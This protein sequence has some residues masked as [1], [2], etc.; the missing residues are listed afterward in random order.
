MTMMATSPQRVR[1]A[2]SGFGELAQQVHAR[3]LSRLPNVEI[4][5]IADPNA[6]RCV[7]AQKVFRD[8]PVYG[9]QDEMLRVA[10]CDAV[11]IAASPSD[12]AGLALAALQHRKHVYLEKPMATSL[13]DAIRLVEAW[14]ASRLVGMIGFN[15]RFTPAV[16]SLR[17]RLRAGQLGEIRAIRTV[18]SIFPRNMPAW[19]TTRRTCGGALLDL[20]P[21]HV[22]LIRYLAQAEVEKADARIW[23]EKTED[24]CAALQMTLTN[25]I[26]VESFFSLCRAEQDVIEIDGDVGTALVDRYGSGRV[27]FISAKHNKARLSRLTDSLARF[28]PTPEMW[29]KLQAPW[30]E[31]SYEAALRTFVAAVRGEESVDYPNFEDGWRC[32]AVI[33]AAEESA[34]TDQ[35]LARTVTPVV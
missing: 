22:D 2:L 6:E 16:Q 9:S 15:Y 19:K 28:L 11:L 3:I 31:P 23:S 1:I 4:A 14:R 24:D 7:A 27:R 18:F 13:P 33:A 20:A 17:A 5:G 34:P 30:H 26:N 25:G 10:K 21:H 12:H 8:A 32:Q 35:V 29:R